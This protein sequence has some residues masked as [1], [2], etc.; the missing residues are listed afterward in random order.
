M[1]RYA[2]LEARAAMHH[3]D[4]TETIDLI[5]FKIAWYRYLV[6]HLVE[7]APRD[8]LQI[9]AERVLAKTVQFPT[10]ATELIPILKSEPALYSGLVGGYVCRSILE[11]LDLYDPVVRPA[12]GKIEM[13]RIKDVFL[14]YYPDA[15]AYEVSD[16]NIGVR[17]PAL[18]FPVFGPDIEDE[19]CAAEIAEA[20]NHAKESDKTK[21]LFE[22]FPWL[23]VKEKFHTGNI[24]PNFIRNHPIIRRH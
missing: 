8:R 1:F 10:E 24:T 6:R 7:A 2:L 19:E 22:R 18:Y 23:K 3:H 5:N 14:F 11:K 17:F 13:G 16:A 20:I 15:N 21:S 4:V 12:P 9:I